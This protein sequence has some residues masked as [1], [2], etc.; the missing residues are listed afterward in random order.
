MSQAVKPLRSH[1][2]TFFCAVVL[3]SASGSLAHASNP[4][5]FV[6]EIITP[7]G[8]ELQTAPGRCAWSGD[9]ATSV[10]IITPEGWADGKRDEP[11][12]GGAVC[13]EL[14]VPSDWTLRAHYADWR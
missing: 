14:V 4:N 13:S 8:W 3:W 9:L 10:E 1:V 11:S 2:R 5:E 6:T 7:A 12:W